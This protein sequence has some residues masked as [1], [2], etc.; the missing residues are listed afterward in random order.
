MNLY[1]ESFRLISNSPLSPWAG[2]LASRTASRFDPR[3]WGDLPMWLETL[4]ALP[5]LN[6]SLL[7]LH[8]PEVTIGSDADADEKTRA[9][10]EA[11]LRRLGPW[12]KGP[13]RLCGLHLDAE[14]RCHL[15]WDRL[16]GHIEPLKGRLVLDV[17]SGNGYHVW[18][19]AGA[20]AK[21]VLGVDPTMKYVMQFQMI[22]H[23]A[24]YPAVT[25]LPLAVED[26]AG[27][28][29]C[30]DTVFSMGLLYHRRDPLEHLRHLK[31]CLRPGGELV[32][33][34]IVVDHTISPLLKPGERYAQMKN[35][36]MIP[37]VPT[38][39]GWLAEA[40]FNDGRL[41]D[42]TATTSEEQRVTAWIGRQ[43]LED[44]LDPTDPNLTIEGY[45]APQRAILLA[46][47]P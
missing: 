22:Q 5:P 33:E 44:F 12:R 27:D 43:S 17:G 23:Y 30:F 3:R 11:L 40:G 16:A 19:M 34:T 31:S 29:G 14:W 32:L 21:L 37:S 13:Y 18:R 36:H 41:I 9:E 45:P 47:R 24:R 20:G 2:Q 1:E 7:E 42:V 10:L 35:V 28:M 26:L 46:T 4:A 15:K 38:L 39:V 6:P 25:V 8:T